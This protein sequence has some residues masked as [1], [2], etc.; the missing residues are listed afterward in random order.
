MATVTVPAEFFQAEL[1][2]YSDWREAFARE[3]LQNAVDANAKHISVSF[4]AE[5]HQVVFADDGVGMT[6]EVLEDVFFALGRTTKVGDTIGG[7]G[8]A[9]I[10]I[11]FAQRR[12]QIRTGN[13]LVR[14][15]GGEYSVRE[16]CGYQ[17]G[18]VFTIELHDGDTDRAR[19]AF[20]GLLRTCNLEVPVT[21]NGAPALSAPPLRRA[22]R[23]LRDDAGVPWAK[24]YVRPDQAGRMVTR[25]HG[26]TMFSRWLPGN[27]D[28]VVEVS[29][30]RSREVLSASRDRLVAPFAEQIDTL[31]ADLSGNRRRALRPSEAPLD[32]RVA[33]GGFLRTDA[34]GTPSRPTDA[35]AASGGRSGETVVRPANQAAA[36]HMAAAVDTGGSFGQLDFGVAQAPVVDVGFDVFLLADTKSARVR[37]LARM[38]DPS[39]WDAHIGHRRKALLLAWKQAVAVALDA[40]VGE[41]PELQSVLWTVGWIFDVDTEALHRQAGDGHVLA[42][43]PVG[44]D[45]VTRFSVSKR[46]DRQRLVA[47]AAHEVAHVAVSDHNESFAGLL[48]N[49]YARID[50]VDADRQVH[51]AARSG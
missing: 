30:Q 11:C 31:V 12:Y 45:G 47:L 32:V 29:P 4:D 51:Q 23:V 18:C 25:V 37:K 42:L 20:A 28:V 17:P 36:A 33:A 5:Q 10:V 38:W 6:R 34:P 2:V 49:L 3:L 1:R 13:L 15:E 35:Q 21:V 26:L 46:A 50:P 48:T 41:R 7:F 9:R 8:R 44:D 14:G 43:N 19:R 40:L 22:V 24:I 16:V 27:D 39:F